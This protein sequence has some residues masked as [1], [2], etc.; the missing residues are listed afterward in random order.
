VIRSRLFPRIAVV[1]LAIALFIAWPVPA[2]AQWHGH[3]HG[4]AYPVYRSSVFV[5]V[6]IGY[7]GYFY[8]WFYP[9]YPYPYGVY[10]PYTP[11]GFYA[12]YGPYGPYGFYGYGR[13]DDFTAELR[14]EVTPR[15]AEVFVDGYSA[16]TVDDFDGTFQRLRMRPGAHEI[17]IYLSGYHAVHDKRYFRPGSN[18][19]IRLAMTPLAPGETADTRP[20]PSAPPADRQSGPPPRRYEPPSERAPEAQ[21]ARFGTLSLRVVPA[22]AELLVDDARW[23]TV[24]GDERTLIRLAEGRHRIEIQKEGY[25][26]YVEEILIRRDQ[27]MTLNVSLVRR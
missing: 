8:P 5:G 19:K 20:E 21:P 15:E 1:G 10:G 27:T 18:E 4:P 7:P 26:R 23:P 11:Y 12:P 13:F 16:G 25:T 9:W 2:R 14:L 22:D 17:T 24:T 3:L 6:G